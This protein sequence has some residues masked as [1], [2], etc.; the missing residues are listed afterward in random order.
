M[1]TSI[2][3]RAAAT[4]P[5]IAKLAAEPLG[6]EDVDVAFRWELQVRR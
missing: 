1:A 2:P 6:D 5:A 3:A 4:C